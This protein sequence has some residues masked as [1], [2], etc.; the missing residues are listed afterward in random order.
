MYNKQQIKE[1]KEL[2]YTS[3][4]KYMGKNK[5][6]LGKKIK[7]I[8]YPTKIKHIYVRLYADQEIAKVMIELQHKDEEI[9]GLF[10][11]QFKQ[12]KTAFENIAGKWNWN[13]LSANDIKLPCSR[14]EVIKENVNIFDKNTWASVF[15]FYEE[16]LIKFDIFWVEFKDVFKQLED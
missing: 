1:T 8:N 3:F 6:V 9:R 4:G 14:I 11:E 13:E 7:W 5:S 15:R 2:F 10:F 12:L 16:N